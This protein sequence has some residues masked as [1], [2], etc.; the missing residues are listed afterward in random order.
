MTIGADMTVLTYENGKRGGACRDFLINSGRLDGHKMLTILPIPTSRDGV[1]LTGSDKTLASVAAEACEGE[2]YLGYDI[3]RFVSDALVG[4]GAR[5]VDAALDEEFLLANARLTAL[6]A[7][8]YLL[9]GG[10]VSP[11]ELR[12]GVV[13]YGRIGKALVRMLL[14]LGTEVRVYSK[15]R[16]VVMCLADSGADATLIAD[17]DPLPEC[18]ILI[19]TAPATI[20]NSEKGGEGTRIIE[21]ASGSNFGTREVE[22]LPALP[23]RYF[24]ESAGRA[25][26]LSLLRGIGGEV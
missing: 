18:D 21:L 3:P 4:V 6:G 2:L 16:G 5:V 26:A 14:A 17:G 24:P 22:R 7:V 19:N 25:Y 11:D 13:G 23:N 12:V 8:A 15:R 20:F 9:T 10:S 1:H